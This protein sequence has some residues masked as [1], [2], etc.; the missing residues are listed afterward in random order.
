MMSHH[1]DD[2][3][4]RPEKHKKRRMET[5]ANDR[6]VREWVQT[7]GDDFEWLANGRVRCRRNGREFVPRLEVLEA[8]VKY[9]R[10]NRSLLTCLWSPVARNSKD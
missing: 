3:R 2:V 6:V 8:F 4:P 7:R 1:R 9:N 10:L 5:D